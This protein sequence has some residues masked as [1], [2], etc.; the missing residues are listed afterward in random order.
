[1]PPL[2]GPEWLF[3]RPARSASGR[4]RQGHEPGFAGTTA[5]CRLPWL[6]TRVAAGGVGRRDHRGGVGVR[7]R[8]RD[9]GINARRWRDH[10]PCN[11]R[12][13]L[14][15]V[16]NG[17]TTLCRPRRGFDTLGRRGRKRRLSLA[18]LSRS[19]LGQGGAGQPA[20]QKAS[21]QEHG[22]SR[23]SRRRPG[24]WPASAGHAVDP[25][26]RHHTAFPVPPQPPQIPL[27]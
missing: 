5:G 3:V 19:R 8:S 16:S 9:A 22:G 1:M 6:H 23:Q 13:L 21:G 18:R 11:A 24:Q 12:P 15:I 4:D 26:V 25:G 7:R 27:P 17:P 20:H 10:A 2:L 14:G